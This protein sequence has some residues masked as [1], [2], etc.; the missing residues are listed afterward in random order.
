[1]KCSHLLLISILLAFT[2]GVQSQTLVVGNYTDAKPD[3]GIFLFSFQPQSGELKKL[4]FRLD[5]VNPSFLCVDSKARLIY[6]CTETKLPQPGSVSVFNYHSENFS[7]SLLN[8]IGSGGENPVFITTIK[9]K[10]VVC[11]YSEGSVSV[12]DLNKDFTLN[13]LLQRI[14][15]QGKSVVAERQEK[16]HPHSAYFHEASGLV[17]IPDLGSDLIRVFEFQEQQQEVLRERSDLTISVNPGGGPRHMAFHPNG[18]WMYVVEELS[19]MVQ[20]LEWDRSNKFKPLQRISSY[21]IPLKQYSGADIHLSPDSRFVYV[22]NRIENSLAIFEINENNGLLNLLG[23]Q[24]T[25]GE[26]PRNFTIDP[27][28]NWLIVANQQSNTLVVFR[29]DMQG[30]GLKQVGNPISVKHPSCL[31][32]MLN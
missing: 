21:Q 2:T 32:W 16:A 10:L 27:S 13:K 29:R 28:G 31:Q 1:M 8:K 6:A 11:N 17:L 15:L 19:G 12:M 26:V 20:V 14:D 9:S 7:L 25:Q 18:N 5:L 4:G 23:H 22:S 30:G 3:T 24:S